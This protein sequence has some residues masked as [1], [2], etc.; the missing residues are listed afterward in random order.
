MNETCISDGWKS[1][2]SLRC[3]EF[4]E[5]DIYKIHANGSRFC[6]ALEDFPI[7]EAQK[8]IS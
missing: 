4:C 6:A 7:S 3:V 5:T 8:D 2:S 1:I